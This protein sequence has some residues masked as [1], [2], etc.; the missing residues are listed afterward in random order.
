LNR[1]SYC[2]NNPLTYTDPC[3]NIVNF[4]NED[5]AMQYLT[6]STD[7]GC[8]LDQNTWA[9]IHDW[10]DLRCAWYTLGTVAPELT[11]Y[12]ANAPETVTIGWGNLD[13][14]VGNTTQASDWNFTGNLNMTLSNSLKDSNS[15]ILTSVMG[16]EGFH[17]AMHIGQVQSWQQSTVAN[18]AFAYSFGYHVSQ[19]LGVN[20]DLFG[21][22]SLSYY[23]KDISPFNDVGTL[24]TQINKD[25]QTVLWNNGYRTVRGSA[26]SGGSVSPLGLW[27]GFNFWFIHSG[28]DSFLTVAKAVWIK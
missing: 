1:Y 23:F 28:R 3:G 22:S 27:P 6:W 11:G 19:A 20:D 15:D 18:E 16:H 5:L 4:Q 2:V 26:G 10:A 24:N 25:T 17:A 12:I 7:Y 8:N 21:A 14:G 13:H 9:I